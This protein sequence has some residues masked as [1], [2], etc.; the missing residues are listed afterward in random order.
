[1]KKYLIPFWRIQDICSFFKDG[2][3][4]TQEENKIN[5]CQEQFCPVL[6]WIKEEKGCK[7]VLTK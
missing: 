5:L 3:T 4:C 1:M 6:K 2:Y 7:M